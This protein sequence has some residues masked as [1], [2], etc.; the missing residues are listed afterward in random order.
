VF[1]I[2]C[3]PRLWAWWHFPP[4]E[5][6]YHYW[7]SESLLTAGALAFGDELTSFIEP[8][9]PAFLA[10]LRATAGSERL[11]LLAQALVAASGGP[12]IFLL[13]ARLSASRAAGL[14]AAAFY[15]F[16][17]YFVRQASSFIE[18]PLLVPLALWSLERF[19]AIRRAPHAALAGAL[20][21]L[22]F[23]TRASLLPVCVGAVAI[24]A[25]R[26]QWRLA[27]S[28]AAAM[29]AV[30]LPWTIRSTRLGNGPLPTRIGENLYLST[31][32][33]AVGVVPVHDIDL[34]IRFAQFRV[35]EELGE[36][37]QAHTEWAADRLLLRH[38]LRF[39]LSNPGDTLA[40]KLQNL[41][42]IP[43]PVL[44]P[45]NAKSEYTHAALIDGRM[46]LT[47]VERRPWTWDLMH[48]AFRSLVLVGA[49][50]GLRRRQGMN[51]GILLCALVSETVVHT[52]FFP[53]TRLLG[54][55]TSVLM[56]YAGIGSLRVLD[57]R[58]AVGE[59]PRS[60]AAS[61]RQRAQ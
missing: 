15:A 39:A 11:A 35:D 1:V 42:W 4:P 41:L 46:Q 48:T 22:L 61:G 51:D 10:I 26:R 45:R 49:I 14:A 6:N 40:L 23:L 12:A 5:P 31:S 18:L 25:G 58:R 53:T 56:V 52:I 17:P 16:D 47:G 19:T 7:L 55:F 44:L 43:A 54:P 21:G 34:L 38:A 57:A 50:A 30:V 27:L 60:A 13:T 9:Y 8:I 24:L 28:V 33:Y 29:S 32:R 37:R 20:F 2:C 36:R 59:P 3:I